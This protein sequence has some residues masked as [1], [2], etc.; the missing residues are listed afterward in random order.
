MESKLERKEAKIRGLKTCWLEGGDEQG[1]IMM[2]LHGYPDSPETFELQ[3][4]HFAAKYHVIAPYSRGCL[5]SEKVDDVRRYGHASQCLDFYEILNHVDPTGKKPIVLVG[6]DLGAAHAWF[7]AGMIQ[8]RL[9]ALV[10]INGL[11]IYQMGRRF[12]NFRQQLK[13]WYI[14]A[15]LVPRL[16]RMILRRFSGQ[17]LNYAYGKSNLSTAA[18]PD[19]KSSLGG[20]VNPSLQYRALV[21]D[22]IKG[23]GKTRKKLDVPVMILWGRDDRFLEVPAK[24]EIERDAAEVT[25]RILKANHWVHREDPSSVNE[26]IGDFI[27]TLGA[28]S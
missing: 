24:H 8:Q 6:H 12:G 7:F 14:Y 3:F 25:I 11:S 26:L 21:M 19:M 27:Q 15:M 2:F 16:P 5:P 18:R 13:S 17:F 4:E 22:L 20:V 9:A 28:K 10:I 23:E 1:P